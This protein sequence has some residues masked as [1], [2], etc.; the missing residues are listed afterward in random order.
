MNRP[1]TI[2]SDPKM[3]QA[4]TLIE[5]LLVLVILSV[6]A[7]IV[8]PKFTSRSEQARITAAETDISALETA[9]DAFEIDTGRYPTADEGIESLL[10]EPAGLR[11][12]SWRGPYLKRGVPLDP[13]GNP[14]LYQQ[15]GQHNIKGFDLSSS[16]PDGQPDTTDDLVNWNL[17]TQ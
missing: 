5:L 16:G 7:A 15:P 14:Y 2:P 8:V 6:L 17:Q 11:A 13:W 1:Q 9:L 12:N 4:F 10:L 3:A